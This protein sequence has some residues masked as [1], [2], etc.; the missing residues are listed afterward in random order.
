MK[1]SV[2]WIYSSFIKYPDI[3]RQLKELGESKEQALKEMSVAYEN[4]LESKDLAIQEVSGI[5]LYFK[6]FWKFESKNIIY[7]KSKCKRADINL[8]QIILVLIHR[9][10]MF[11]VQTTFWWVTQPFHWRGLI[12]RPAKCLLVNIHLTWSVLETLVS[13]Y[14]WYYFSTLW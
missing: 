1:T 12:T 9:L 2:K 14:Y 4:Q 7:N 10:I 11:P 8:N 3:F 13:I 6:F 5:I